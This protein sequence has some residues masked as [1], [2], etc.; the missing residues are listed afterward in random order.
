MYVCVRMC[1]H[2]TEKKLAS[3]MLKFLMNY[4]DFRRLCIIFYRLK[5]PKVCSADC[6]NDQR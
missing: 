6:L 3:K 2:A 4:D 5:C 1:A